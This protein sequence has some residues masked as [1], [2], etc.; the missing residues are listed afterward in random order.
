MRDERYLPPEVRA[1]FI[2]SVLTKA[3]IPYGECHCG[4]GRQTTIAQKTQTRI[5]QLKG[6]PIRYIK[7]HAEGR[8]GIQYMI[9]DC[10][11]VTPCWVWQRK[12]GRDGYGEAWC[13]ERK[14]SMKAHRLYYEQHVGPIP[15]GMHVDH[16]CQNVAC[17]NPNHLEPSTPL[18]NIRRSRHAKLTMEDARAIRLS[19]KT[20]VELAAEYGVD[21][22]VISAIRRHRTWKEDPLAMPDDFAILNGFMADPKL[23]RTMRVPPGREHKTSPVLAAP[24]G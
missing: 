16:K 20:G 3:G 2:S 15:A 14:Q 18:D 10:G 6:E 19:P 1:E 9:E 11:Y 7:G 17:V 8:G 4:C 12:C 22:S 24:V 13:G 23:A 5:K 21:K